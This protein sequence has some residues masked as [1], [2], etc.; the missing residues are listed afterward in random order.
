MKDSPYSCIPRNACVACETATDHQEKSDSQ[1]AW[2]PDRQTH[3]WSWTKWSLGAAMLCKRHD[4]LSEFSSKSQQFPRKVR[5]KRRTVFVRGVKVVND[6]KLLTISDVCV[7]EVHTSDHGSHR[8][9]RVSGLHLS[10]LT[11]SI[12]EVYLPSVM[13]VLEKYTHQT[14]DPI[15]S[16]GFLASTCR[17]WHC[18]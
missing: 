11:L 14:M 5:I 7:G 10:I 16:S 3:G 9:V 17:S 2:L 13:Y 18:P 1:K 12:T 8:L 15:D 4:E 6:F